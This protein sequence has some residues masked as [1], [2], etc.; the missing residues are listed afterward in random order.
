MAYSSLCLCLLF[1]PKGCSN[2]HPFVVDNEFPPYRLSLVLIKQQRMLD[3]NRSWAYLAALWRHPWTVISKCCLVYIYT[4][5][6]S[7]NLDAFTVTVFSIFSWLFFL[8]Q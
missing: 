3:R 1:N 5:S 2:L 6:V 8:R 4:S 7:L